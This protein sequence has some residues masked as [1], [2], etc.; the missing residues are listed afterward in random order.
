MF[1]IVYLAISINRNAILVFM[2]ER[3]REIGKNIKKEIRKEEEEK[4]KRSNSSS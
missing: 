4:K 2:T 3:E 1:I